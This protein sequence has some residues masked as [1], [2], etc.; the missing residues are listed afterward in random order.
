MRVVQGGDGAGLALEPLLQIGVRG[1]MLGQDL[2]GDGAIRPGV[3][4][5][6]ASREPPLHPPVTSA[7]RRALDS[8]PDA[9]LSR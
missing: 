6:V 7:E 2:D 3:A 9:A 8:P 5:L 1:D 4:G